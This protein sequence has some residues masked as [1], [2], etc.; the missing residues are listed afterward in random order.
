ML[1]RHVVSGGYNRTDHLYKKAKEEGYRSR[2]AYKLIEL[3]QRFH[4][5]TAGAR[6]LDLGAWPGGWLQVASEVVGTDG[7][8]VGIDLVPIEPLPGKNVHL[9]TG[10]AADPEIQS[11]AFALAGGKFNAVLSDMSPKLSGIK[12]ADRAATIGCAELA[13]GIAGQTLELGGTL[14][15]KL[16]KSNEAEQFVKSIRPMFNKVSRSELDATRKTSNEF[17][18]V[19]SGFKGVGGK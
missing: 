14:I 11:R 18:V 13:L 17:Y 2:A 16:F 15:I 6:V 1:E 12:E 19:G 9:I 5:L 10:N 4:A 3:N 7:I 8:V